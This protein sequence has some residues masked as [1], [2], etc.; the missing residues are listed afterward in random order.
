MSCD[1]KVDGKEYS[2]MSPANNRILNK[3]VNNEVYCNM[4]EEIEF[5]IAAL[6][7]GADDSDAPSMWMTTMPP[8]RTVWNMSART[9]VPAMISRTMTR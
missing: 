1:Y 3:L 8:S 5:I 2:M 7:A 9:A 4:T 6:I